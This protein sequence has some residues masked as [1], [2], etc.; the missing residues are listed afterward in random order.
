MAHP[1]LVRLLRWHTLER[2]GELARLEQTMGST[3]RKLAALAQAQEAGKVDATLPPAEL[4]AVIVS[5]AQAVDDPAPAALAV[6]RET[7]ATTVRRLVTP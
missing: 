4:L 6:R 3:A 5:L 2:P 7:V 1:E